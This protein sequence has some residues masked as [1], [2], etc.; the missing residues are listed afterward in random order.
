M[1]VPK[2]SNKGQYGV[3]VIQFP[4]AGLQFLVGF[5]R[6]YFERHLERMF[7]G[8]SMSAGA[9]NE[10]GMGGTGR[11]DFAKDTK[12]LLLKYDAENQAETF[13]EDLIPTLQE[14][15]RL[16]P[17][18]KYHFRYGVPDPQ[19]EAKLGAITKAATL[20]GKKLAYK[21]D[22]VRE[23]VGMS[24]PEE[25]DE[26]IGGDDPPPQQGLPGPQQPVPPQGPDAPGSGNSAPPPEALPLGKADAPADVEGHAGAMSPDLLSAWLK[27]AE[28]GDWNAARDLEELA[29]DPEGL[30]GLLEDI[31]DQQPSG[32]VAIYAW[33]AGAT[34][35]GRTKAIGT[36]EH[37]GKTLYGARAEAA[38][39]NQGRRAEGEDYRGGRGWVNREQEITSESAV[40]AAINDPLRLTPE[41]I[42][43]L[44]AHM[45]GL[46]RDRLRDLAGQIQA[47]ISGTK[48]DLA[49]RLLLH[50]HDQR[51]GRQRTGQ[52]MEEDA[53]LA[54]RLQQQDP[55]HAA[56]RAIRQD[57]ES[58]RILETFQAQM[59]PL[60]EAVAAKPLHDDVINAVGAADRALREAATAW[61]GR[62]KP[63]YKAK[64]QAIAD[65][66]KRKAHELLGAYDRG[67]Q[68]EQDLVIKGRQALAQLIAPKTPPKFLHRPESSVPRSPR[69]DAVFDDAHAFVSSVAEWAGYQNYDVTVSARA[70]HRNSSP[71]VIAVS[72]RHAAAATSDYD[73]KAAISTH[74]HELGHMLEHN[75]PGIKQRVQ[76]FLAYRVAS[77]AP[78]PMTTVDP[79]AQYDPGETGRKNHFDRAF[80][81]RS[82][83][84][85]G[86]DYGGRSS[87]IVSMGL[88][89]LYDAPAELA[90]KDPEYFAFMVSVLR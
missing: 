50:V 7:V 42:T 64:K 49:D 27:A 11:A 62:G 82:A 17:D 77:E 29:A 34:K 57:T 90:E 26:I 54:E 45:M 84:Y 73:Q 74:V 46:S 47:N 56:A 81:V 66:L 15:N 79:G 31:E 60:R 4:I 22:E 3:Q 8:Q 88:Q 63:E 75:K 2:D 25:G 37:A 44:R 20:P 78:T 87:E 12:Y 33:V 10:S 6:D 80:P 16:D 23:L 30:A 85:V 65:E 18:W 53:R 1:P 51:W 89:K 36:G 68:A 39:R 52:A 35:G 19:A 70:F 69:Q 21:A 61:A 43:A 28:A 71:P 38:L 32:D 13:S 76:D 55:T 83:Y 59:R 86:K 40:A 41:H 14:F 72:T 58:L 9:D 67:R 24:K 5:V 48:G